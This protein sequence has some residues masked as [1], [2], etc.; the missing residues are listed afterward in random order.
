MQPNLLVT[1]E[2]AHGGKAMQEV[3][4]FLEEAGEKVEFHDSGTDGVFFV[5][6]GDA[7]QAVRHLVGLCSS[8]PERFRYTQRWIPVE[9]WVSSDIDEMS[10][11][12]VEMNDRIDDG[13]KWKIDIVKRGYD[14]YGTPELI[15]TLTENID[16][17]HVDLKNPDKIVK[18]EIFG[19]K[20]AVA[21]LNSDELLEVAKM[22]K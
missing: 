13:E 8:S 22:K 19:E 21:L 6:V 3:K 11:V 15:K 16:R 4:L 12:M 7:K 10:S 5:S 1:Y 9:R 18:V 17:Q 14:R 2:P 20:A